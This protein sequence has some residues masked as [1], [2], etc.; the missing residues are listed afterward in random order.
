MTMTLRDDIAAIKKKLITP[1]RIIM[2]HFTITEQH[3]KLLQRMNVDWNDDYYGAPAINAK[4]PYGNGDVVDDIMDILGLN[5]W[6][7]PLTEMLRCKILD[8]H[9]ETKLALQ[10]CLATQSFKPGKYVAP[11]YTNDWAKVSD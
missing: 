2:K 3:L 5:V 6:K 1:Q 9:Q 4:R 10:I 7:A 8:L 11:D